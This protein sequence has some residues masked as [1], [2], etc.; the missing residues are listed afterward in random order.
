MR[1]AKIKILFLFFLLVFSK[2][3]KATHNRAGEITFV[4]TGPLAIHAVIT[5]YTK[6]SSVAADR[7]S[8]EIYWGD[9]TSEFLVR[10]NGWGYPQPNDVKISYYEG[11]HTFPARG[12]YTMSMV[13]PNRIAGILNVNF[14]DS[15]NVPF[16]LET[17]FSFLNTQFQGE[18]NSVVLLQPPIDI[19]CVGQIFKH[20]PNAYD[21]DGDSISYE[22]IVPLQAKNTPVPDYKYPD[23]IGAGANNHFTFNEKTGDL[24]WDTPQIAGDYN[25]AFKVNE[26]RNGKLITSTIRDMQIFITAMCNSVPP[27]MII[28]SDKCMIAGD[29][30]NIKVTAKDSDKRQ[31][32]LINASGEPFESKYGKAFLENNNIF[33]NSPVTSTFTWQTACEH[34]ANPYYQI[35]FKAMDNSL[36]DTSGLVDLKIFK[37]KVS[38]PPPDNPEATI[39][40]S[41]IKL[42][43]SFPYPCINSDNGYFRGFSIWRRNSSNN[44]PLDT[45]TPGLDSRGYKIIEHLTNEDDGISYFYIDDDIEPGQIYCYRILAE[46]A[47]KTDNGFPYNPVQSLPSEET[48]EFVPDDRP[49]IT[50][51]DVLSTD[52]TT[53]KIQI[54]W[55]KPDISV[56]DTL[57]YS[58][59][60]KYRLLKSIGNSNNFEYI[61]GTEIIFNSYFE[62]DTMK[63]EDNGLNTVYDQYFYKVELYSADNLHSSSKNASSIFLSANPLDEK[64]KLEAKLDI[65]WTNSKYKFYRSDNFAGTYELIG[66]NQIPEYIDEGLTNGNNYCYYIESYGYYGSNSFKIINKSQISCT[67]PKDNEKPCSPGLTVDNNCDNINIDEQYINFLKWTS[68]NDDCTNTDD[69]KAY[70]I[71][72][73]NGI[74]STFSLLFS[75]NNE[76]TNDTV[77]TPENFAGC[78]YI[79]AIDQSGN[80]SDPSN[81]VCA[82]SCPLYILPNTFTP[83]GDGENDLFS[84]RV[85]RHINKIDL[86][87]YDQWGILVFKTNN[88]DILWD[89]TNM[90]GKKL[91]RGTY[92]YICTPYSVSDNLNTLK[93][94]IEIIY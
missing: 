71:Y 76:E 65:P 21:I 26:Y 36:S 47:H 63:Y 25:V 34:V 31:K 82:K 91:S 83:N 1:F 12:T 33:L 46:Y 53:G 64:I 69:V 23:V 11:N 6:T 92:Y 43:W 67:S 4:Q 85:K 41:G 87:V 30:L 39:Y 17:T 80:E 58:P 51:A 3:M 59:P 88:P 15:E 10:S 56:F 20:N 45:C 77:H 27:E 74:D 90:S 89:G 18:N 61:N 32:V 79:T 16:Y 42:T 2:E 75:I 50:K 14:P 62:Q 13:D 94:Y 57:K 52:N 38:G 24:I 66:T 86:K 70:K 78:Y 55:I 8:V 72:F 60:Y 84:P 44:F 68:P 48:C 54:D 29:T 73:S 19:G 22:L 7:D 37:V 93:G 5:L 9:G 49:I 40:N 28:P 81:I 35:L